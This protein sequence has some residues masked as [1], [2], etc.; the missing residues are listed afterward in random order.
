MEFPKLNKLSQ[1][2]RMDRGSGCQRDVG[3]SRGDHPD[4]NLQA[5]A[6]YILD[7]DRAVG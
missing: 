7:G 4:W 5:F 6:V 3:G 2:G 1:S